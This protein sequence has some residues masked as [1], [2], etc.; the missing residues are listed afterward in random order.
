MPS[1]SQQFPTTAAAVLTDAYSETPAGI[2][3]GELRRGESFGD[4]RI[5]GVDVV[6]SVGGDVGRISRGRCGSVCTGGG[7]PIIGSVFAGCRGA[8]GPIPRKTRRRIVDD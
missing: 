3:N 2:G 1:G 4:A 6:A 8:R 5:P 7:G